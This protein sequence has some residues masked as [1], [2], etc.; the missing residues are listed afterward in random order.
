[1]GMIEEDLLL[2]LF[3]RDT[4]PKPFAM[5]NPDYSM[6]SNSILQLHFSCAYPGLGKIFG[7]RSL[8]RQIK[9]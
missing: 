8:D 5:R 1:A 4:S 7:D 6:D 3:S 2:F 9:F